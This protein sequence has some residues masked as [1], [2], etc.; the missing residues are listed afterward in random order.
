MGRPELPIAEEE[1]SQFDVFET[2]AEIYAFVYKECGKRALHEVLRKAVKGWRNQRQFEEIAAELNAVGLRKV[3]DIV[4][5]YAAKAPHE[6]DQCPYPDVPE[7]ATSRRAWFYSVRQKYNLCPWC[8]SDKSPERVCDN[9]E[10]CVE[11]MDNAIARSPPANLP[12]LITK[13]SRRTTQ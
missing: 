12:R 7:K 10:G 2:S 3:A 4:L 6:L 13:G 8:G 9:G 11:R 5:E 1:P